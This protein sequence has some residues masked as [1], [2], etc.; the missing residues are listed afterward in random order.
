VIKKIVMKLI[1]IKLFAIAALLFSAVSCKKVIDQAPINST[2]EQAFWKNDKDFDQALSGAYSLLRKSL[3]WGKWGVEGYAFWAYGDIAAGEFSTPSYGFKNY[4]LNQVK[5]MNFNGPSGYVDGFWDWRPHYKVIAQCNLILDKIN[6]LPSS[7]IKL[8]DPE[9]FKKQITGEVYFIRAF[10]YFYLTRIWGDVPLIT[11]VEDPLHAEY[12]ERAPEA[13][14]I[15]Q[16][17]SDAQKAAENLDWGYE[18]NSQIAV[19]ANKGSAYALLAHANMWKGD[20]AAAEIATNEV[21]QNGGYSLEPV[22]TYN[23]VFE[24]KSNEGIFEIAMSQEF[25]EGSNYGFYMDCINEPYVFNTGRDKTQYSYVNS[26][27]YNLYND[28]ADKRKTLFFDN[29][30]SSKIMLTK[31]NNVTYKDASKKQNASLSNNII[32][33]R[34]AD[35]MLLRAEALAKLS[36]Y[37]DAKD[38]LDQVRARV[39]AG[40]YTGTLDDQLYEYIIDERTRELFG[41]GHRFYD[42][43]R[44]GFLSKKLGMSSNRINQKGYYWPI[45]NGLITENPKLTQTLFWR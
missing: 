20:A 22:S 29:S 36:R 3:L 42:L 21:I 5:D 15:Q 45:D 11:K 18:D 19:R 12:L 38:L 25:Q 9:K 17:L 28:P 7:A 34:L 44:S 14:I 35:I 37:A 1:S 30:V 31:F 26:N 10:T 13:N 2:F 4:I 39:E 33:F 16:V 40:P 23:R 8:D 6:T 43:I 27:A 24:G 32:V 41:E